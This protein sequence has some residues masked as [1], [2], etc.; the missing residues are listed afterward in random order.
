MALRD[1]APVQFLRVVELV[2]AGHAAGVEVGDVLDVVADGADD[3]A[4]HD[5]H[6]VDV[7]EQLHARRVH[8][9]H[10]LDAP[11]GVVALVV[12]VIHLAVQQFQ[13]D[14]DAVVFGHLLDALKPDDAVVAAFV[15]GQARRGCRRT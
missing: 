15:V 12:L 8:A 2:P 13:A 1:G 9:L 10:H 5:L 7:V 6:V 3:V 11:R 4:L 14:R